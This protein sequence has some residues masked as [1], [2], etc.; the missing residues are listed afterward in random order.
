M[1]PVDKNV[2]LVIVVPLARER[3]S[4]WE[5]GPEYL[6]TAQILTRMQSYA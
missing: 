4:G 5:G 3:N 2:V 6:K 1:L